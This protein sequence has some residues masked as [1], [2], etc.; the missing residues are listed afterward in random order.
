MAKIIRN[1]PSVSDRKRRSKPSQGKNVKVAFAPKDLASRIRG[2]Y[3]RVA[4]QLDVDPSYV[5]RVARSERKSR[6][7]AAALER[8]LWKI[9]SNITKRRGNTARKATR[10]KRSKNA[11]MNPKKTRK[12]N[13][14]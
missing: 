13:Q 12:S 14:S 6:A 7:I 5:S 1:A 10:K 3:R 2:I 11:K 4:L 9:L 8:E